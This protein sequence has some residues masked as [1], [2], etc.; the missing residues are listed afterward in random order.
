MPVNGGSPCY[1]PSHAVDL[2]SALTCIAD[3]FQKKSRCPKGIEKA[4]I[5]KIDGRLRRM[6]LSTQIDARRR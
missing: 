3:L 1:G 6:L 2:P 4:G 5:A